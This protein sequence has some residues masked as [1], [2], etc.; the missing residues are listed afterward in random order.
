MATVSG[1]VGGWPVAW[2]LWITPKSVQ[3]SQLI[4]FLLSSTG[5]SGRVEKPRLSD[6]GLKAGRG[7]TPARLPPDSLSESKL[8]G[9]DVGTVRSANR[10]A[11]KAN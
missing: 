8:V 9:G 3:A 11:S 10:L 2:A 5:T 1:W 6:Q 4:A 7:G